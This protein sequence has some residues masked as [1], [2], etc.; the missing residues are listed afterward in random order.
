MKK[1]Q[2]NLNDYGKVIFDPHS[3]LIKNT[4]PLRLIKVSVYVE[5]LIN[6]SHMMI[7]DMKIDAHRPKLGLH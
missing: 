1:G 6:C 5:F 7:D 2:L 4:S 3:D